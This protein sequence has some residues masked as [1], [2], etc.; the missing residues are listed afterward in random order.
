MLEREIPHFVGRFRRCRCGKQPRHV[1]STGRSSRE[2]IISL[3]EAR[4]LQGTTR[5]R[6]ECSCGAVTARHNTLEVAEAQWGSDYAQLSL[7]SPR[8]RRRKAG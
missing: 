2:P 3:A 5:H 1:R 4:S 8:V 7:P 6:L